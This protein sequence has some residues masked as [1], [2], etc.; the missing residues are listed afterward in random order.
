MQENIML[1]SPDSQNVHH[2]GGGV[3]VTSAWSVSERKSSDFIGG[4]ISLHDTKE[5]R[6]YL[7]GTVLEVINLGNKGYK[8]NRVSFVFKRSTGRRVIPLQV[9]EKYSNTITET[10]EQIRY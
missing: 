6:S 10:R 7:R 5:D 4:Q 8:R 9:R 1:I 2:L 3:Y